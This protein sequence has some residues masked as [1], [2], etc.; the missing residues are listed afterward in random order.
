MR[1]R[2]KKRNPVQL[3][4][5]PNATHSK[6]YQCPPPTPR[7]LSYSILVTK[8]LKIRSR[9]RSHLRHHR[10]LLLCAYQLYMQLRGLEGE[11]HREA[12]TRTCFDGVVA[13]AAIGLNGVAKWLVWKYI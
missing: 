5:E 3:T 4:P 13:A 8:G 2:K 9:R 7:S 11:L 12:G 10:L 6:E 1:E